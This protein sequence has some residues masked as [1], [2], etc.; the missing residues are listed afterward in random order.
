[1]ARQLARLGQNSQPR[2]HRWP[3]N[4]ARRNLRTRWRPA[5]GLTRGGCSS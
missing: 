5:A 2:G 3:A 1:M 4:M